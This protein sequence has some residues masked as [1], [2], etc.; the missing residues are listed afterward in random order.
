[1]WLAGCAPREPAQTGKLILVL[2]DRSQSTGPDRELYAQAS[3]RILSSLRP[4]DRL[5]AG[6]ITDRSAADFRTHLDEELPPALPAMK[7]TDVP[8]QYRESQ[9]QWERDSQA[10]REGIQRK[11]RDLLAWES[12]AVRTKIFESLRVAGQILGSERRPNKHLILLSDMIEDSEIANFEQLRLDEAFIR[13]EIARQQGAGIL[14]ALRGVKV[15]VAGA[16]AESLER[17]AAIEKFWREYFAAAGAIIEAGGY[18][19]ALPKLGE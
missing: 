2:V 12:S 10:R 1:L 8:S 6:Y 5:V 9:A 16:Q 7:I 17:S 4:G 3:E 15:Y 14:P 19:R 11:L 18:S 13:K